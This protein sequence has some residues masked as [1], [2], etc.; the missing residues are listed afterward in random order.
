[1]TREQ[2]WAIVRLTL[3][4]LQVMTAA[5]AAILLFRTGVNAFSLGV[6]AIAGAFTLTSVVLFRNPGMKR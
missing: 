5:T 4:M 6:A 2:K 3:G 1:M